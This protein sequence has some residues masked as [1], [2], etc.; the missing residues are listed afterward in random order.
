[1]KISKILLFA[2]LLLTATAVSAQSKPIVV[3][4]WQNGAPNDNGA[5]GTEYRKGIAVYN[6]VTPSITVYPSKK[7]NSKAIVCCPGGG[8][9]CECDSYEGH[10]FAAWFN[11]MNITFIVLK[12]RLPYTH[13]E[14]P[15]SD[16]HQAITLVRQHAKEWNVDPDEVGIMGSSAGG[17]LAAS[18][19]NIFTKETRPD[20]QILLY[21]VITMDL[22]TTHKGT[23]KNLIGDNPS[24]EMIKRYSMEQQVSDQ[25]PRAFITL[26]S[27]DKTVPPVNSINYYMALINHHISASMFIYPTGGHGFG[28]RDNFIYKRQWTGELEKW[29]ESF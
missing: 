9:S 15:L 5:T 17:H 29:L 12:Y 16:V 28:F 11:A 22:N 18:A 2:V 8:Y 13:N 6:I 10:D 7:A 26:A 23:R 3:N 24:E 21:P 1:M 25:T 19:A 14:V 4:L 20:F 27:D